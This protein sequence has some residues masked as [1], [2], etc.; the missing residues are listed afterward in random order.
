MVFKFTFYASCIETQNYTISIKTL[1]VTVSTY[2]V[3]RRENLCSFQRALFRQEDRVATAMCSVLS[4]AQGHGL[5]CVPFA[6]TRLRLTV[7]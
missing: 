3:K 2:L 5:I 4:E 7:F 6:V 1:E